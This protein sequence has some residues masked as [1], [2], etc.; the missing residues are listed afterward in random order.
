MK[1]HKNSHSILHRHGKNNSQLHMGK[2]NKT[3]KKIQGSKTFKNIR[4]YG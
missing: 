3:K 2:Q 1:S 4:T